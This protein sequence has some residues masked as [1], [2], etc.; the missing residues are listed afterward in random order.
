MFRA[1]ALESVQFTENRVLQIQ[2]LIIEQACNTGTSRP[3]DHKSISRKPV[4][5]FC[6]KAAARPLAA[7]PHVHTESQWGVMTVLFA[8]GKTPP[9]SSS[10]SEM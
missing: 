5:T 9:G 4:D 6:N 2:H 3:D 8:L 10:A 1:Y 7:P